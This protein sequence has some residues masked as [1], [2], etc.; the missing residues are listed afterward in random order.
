M[1][2]KQ[3]FDFSKLP[4]T[5][6]NVLSKPSDCT[7]HCS[8]MEIAT[9]SVTNAFNTCWDSTGSLYE[10]VKKNLSCAPE[11]KMHLKIC[12]CK[13]N[14]STLRCKYRKSGLKCS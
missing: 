6:R 2:S 4:P 13:T 5:I 14:C 10:A 11:S 3:H 1:F 7:L 9:D 8:L 12:Y